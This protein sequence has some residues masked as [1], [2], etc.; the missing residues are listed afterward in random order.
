M[1]NNN[2]IEVLLFSNVYL[3]YSYKQEFINWFS[4]TVQVVLGQQEK[5]TPKL[6]VPLLQ[7]LPGIY[8]S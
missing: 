5:T 2:R 7:E 8:M 4:E 1:E 6:T 3:S